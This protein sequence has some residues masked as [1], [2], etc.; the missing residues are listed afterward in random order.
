MKLDEPFAAEE[1]AGRNERTDGLKNPDMA[2]VI[3]RE[4]ENLFHTQPSELQ[5]ILALHKI[6]IA[7]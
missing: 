7:A 4:L 1:L 2:E 3:V 5:C 6:G